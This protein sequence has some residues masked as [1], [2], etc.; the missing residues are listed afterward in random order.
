M[1]QEISGITSDKKDKNV[2]I[3]AET[4]TD[5]IPFYKEENYVLDNVNFI[6]FIKN[7]E[8][9]VRTSKEYKAY[10][11]YL[12]EDLG[13]NHCMVYSNITDTMTPIEMH[14]FLFTLFDC[15]EIIIGWFFKTHTQ[16]SS[17]RVFGKIMEEHRNNNIS[18]MMLSESVHAA[19]HNK[20]KNDD[21]RLL[22]YRMAHGNIVGFLNNYYQALSFNHIAKIKR[23]MEQYENYFNN[24]PDKF[25]DTVI[26]KWSNEIMVK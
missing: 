5:I 20:N 15:V 25:F 9:Q 17:S 7:V 22:D 3:S 2:I 6:K 4:S 24:P 8:L 12:K 21:V 23:Y 10:I 11:R 1:K 16:F 26:T 14:H 13:L 19:V 18:V